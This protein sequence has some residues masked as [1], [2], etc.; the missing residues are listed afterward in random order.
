[1][2]ARRRPFRAARGARR[3]GLV[4]LGSSAVSL[5]LLAV[6]MLVRGDAAYGFLPWNL[7]LAWIPLLLALAVNAAWRSG[8]RIAVPPLLVLWLLFFPNA[9]YVVTDFVHLRDIGGMPRWFDVIMLGSFALTSLATGFVA[10]YLVQNLI[11]ATLGVAWGWVGAL[12]VIALSGIGIYLG[13]VEQLNSWD[14]LD[15]TRLAAALDPGDV[16]EQGHRVL[17]TAFLTCVLAAGYVVGRHVAGRRV[18]LE[19]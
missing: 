7:F 13:R 2:R 19:R 5:A 3:I 11:R 1:M 17:L 8:V 16:L 14:V 9:P 12:A 4:L 15:P 18:D 6:R 10:L